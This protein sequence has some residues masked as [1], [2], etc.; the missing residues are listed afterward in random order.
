MYVLRII[1]L[2]TA[3]WTIAHQTPL[4]MKFPRQEDKSGLPFA[5]PGDLPKPGIKPTSLV[6]PALAGQFFTI[7]TTWGPP[8]NVVWLYNEGKGIEH[9]YF[10][11]QEPESQN[12]R[13]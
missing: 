9:W 13:A 10:H 12:P 8:E 1:Q 7:S 2:F 11:L 6:S 5:T 4:S 3:P